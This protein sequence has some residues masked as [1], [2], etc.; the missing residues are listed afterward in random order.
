LQQLAQHD[1]EIVAK[2]PEIKRIKKRA[3]AGTC[4]CCQRSFSNM[5][6][7]MKRQHPDYVKES[8]ANVVPIKAGG[9]P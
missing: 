1:D 7:H 5:A 9:K 4:P 6:T 8:G 3:A 2:E